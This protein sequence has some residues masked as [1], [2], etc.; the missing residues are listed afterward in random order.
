MAEHLDAGVAAQEQNGQLRFHALDETGQGVGHGRTVRDGGDARFAGHAGVA[1]GHEHDAGL[2]GGPNVIALLL[3]DESVD[4]VDIGIAD[5]AEHRLDAV[6]AQGPGHGRM[7][8]DRLF[9]CFAHSVNLAPKRATQVYR[10]F[11][12][13]PLYLHHAT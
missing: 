7:E 9:A 2:G 12:Y 11:L 4:H 8:I 6:V 1:Q 13:L 3:A 5:Q 10:P